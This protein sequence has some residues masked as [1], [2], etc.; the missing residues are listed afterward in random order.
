MGTTG[1]SEIELHSNISQSTNENPK[2]KNK[3][4]SQRPIQGY[5]GN[6]NN[7]NTD[8]LNSDNAQQDLR[9]PKDDSHYKQYSVLNNKTPETQGMNRSAYG[10]SAYPQ[11][12]T[13][14][15]DYVPKTPKIENQN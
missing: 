12:P 13:K 11:I 1:D 3:S 15:N 4:K 14:N 8:I 6:K 2:S 5:K 9:K 10:A 7:N